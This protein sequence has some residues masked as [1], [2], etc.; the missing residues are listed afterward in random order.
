MYKQSFITILLTVL[1][2]MTGAK[3]FAHDIYAAYNGK[4]IYYVWTNNNTELAVS[5]RGSSSTSYNNEYTG[6]VEIP[7]SVEYKG[8]TYPVTYIS[9]LAF[10]GCSSLTSVTIPI[11]VTSIGSEAFS[12]C[13]G[14]TSVTIPNSVESI[15]SYAF[16]E[17]S[18]LRSVT[19]PGSVTDIGHYAFNNCSSLK[20]VIVNCS[21]TTIG[22]RPFYNCNK[23]EEVSF[24]C[25]T[26]SQLFG[27]IG[28]KKVTLSE[29][30]KA[31]GASAL[32]GFSITSV[33]IPNSVTRIGTMAFEECHGLTSI[34]IPNSVT[35][36]GYKAF[37]FCGGLTTIV[38]E[39]E[40]P[41]EIGSIASTSVTLIVPAGTKAAYQSTA[42]W[43][44]FTKT[45]EIGEGGYAGCKF[46]NN[47]IIYTIGEN[48]TASLTSTNKS[49]S[50]AVDIPSQV[51][52]NG[53]MYDMTS[54]ADFA[55]SGRSLTSVTIPNSVTSIGKSAFYGC[56]ALGSVTIPNSVTSVGSSAF[57]NTAWYVNQP[58]GLIYVG[59]VAYKYKGEM[60]ENT[61]I[62]INDGTLG[63]AD[64]VFCDHYNLRSIT[65]PNS[66]TS[67]GY[68]AFRK[69]NGL[70]SVNISDMAAWCNIKFSG[71]YSNPLYCAHHLYINGNEITN[72]V[73]PN[74]VTSIGSCAFYGCTG[75]T[76]ATIP[77][78]VTSIGYDA[79]R[80]C[81]GLRSVTIPNSVT[82]IDS[83]AFSGCRRL[84]S[85][86]IPNSVTSI[87]TGVFYGCY[88][89]GSVTIP[90]SVTSI[91]DFAFSGCECLSSVP[92]PN[93]VTSIGSFAF[94]R[95]T[96]FTSFTIPNSVT[97]IGGS[98]FSNCINLTSITIP[99]GVT[100]IGDGAFSG[101]SRLGSVTIPNSVT[102]ISTGV[103]SGCSG[104]RSVTIP[105][106]VT[107]IGESAFYGCDLTFITIPNSVTSIGGSA[108]SNSTNLTTIVSEIKNP[109]IINGSLTNNSVTLVVPVGTKEA[110]QSTSGWPSKI[111]EI[112]EGDFAGCIFEIDGI[113]Y[114]IG[115]NNTVST[116]AN[117]AIS[118]A[119]IIPS[120][121]ELKGKKY[122]VTSIGESAFY[123][124]SGL[125]SV[126]IPNSVTSIGIQAFYGCY[127]LKSAIIGS[128]VLSIGADAFSYTNLK[129]TIWLTNTPPSGYNNAKGTVNYVSND[130]FNIDNKVVYKHLSSNFVV[131]GIRYVP[132]NPSQYTCDAIDCTYN[133]SVENINIGE[134][135]TNK[136]I[137]LTVLK[138]NP[139]TCYQNNHIKDVKLSLGGD[140]GGDAFYGCAGLNTA[141]VSNKGAIGIFAFSYCSA[142]ETAELGQDVTSIGKCA[143]SGCS[144]LES[145][146][147]P[148]AVVSIGDNAFEDCTSIISANIGNGVVTINSAA[149]AG[150]SSLSAITIPQSVKTI[151]YSVFYNCTSLA[152]VTIAD[153]ETTLTLYP[154]GK[155]PTFSSCPLDYVYIGRD[156]SYSTSSDYGYSPFYNNTSLRAVKI[157]DKETEISEKEFY[158]C[159]NLQQVEIGDGVTTIGSRAFSG[160]SGLTSITIPNCVE[161][162]SSYAFED[163]ISLTSVVIPDAVN[164]LGSYVFKDCA[165]MTSAKIGNGIETIDEYT[166]SGCT[167]LNE[168]NIGSK[169]ETIN[170]YAFSGCSALPSITIPKAVTTIDDY[171][172]S[173]CASLAEVTIADSET[174]LTLGSNGSNPIFSDCPLNNVYIGRDISYKT[175]SNYGYSPFYRNTS[176]RVVK[177]A[178]SET[179]ISENEFYGCTNLRQVEIGDGMTTI[180]NRAFS[181]CSS[182][183]F[184]AFG[185]QMANIGQE[186]FSDCTALVA[187]TSKAQTPPVCG[188]QALDDI[189]RWECKLYVPKGYLSVYQAADQW[190]DFWH[191][192]EG[193]YIPPM[194]GD[195]NS[196]G[197]VDKDDLRDL[198][199]YIMGDKPNG[200]TE[201]SA[202]VNGDNK[203]NITDI[204]VL[205]TLLRL[206]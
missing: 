127:N 143:F 33:T 148:D 129:K 17:C 163:C 56:Y 187:I 199:A 73:I 145:I 184:F 11:S 103:F 167:S 173:N 123:G 23:I 25:E 169:V 194:E 180:G 39:I 80:D 150:C 132:V 154:V 131:D 164:T 53:K 55:F 69:C 30:I 43:S 177:I 78:S 50:G 196:D 198:V 88:A 183:K 201:E 101:C 96:C 117:N 8:N 185:S 99:N 191:M 65:I 190:M 176:L 113:Y 181:G 10:Y 192:Y 93:S 72:L 74:S 42:G 63:I 171:V 95:C 152:K 128:G 106:S 5:Y 75:L 104:L 89:L 54:I 7:N 57:S 109:F 28:I 179:E 162:I 142:L 84:E 21:P 36:I 68:D 178:D 126:T 165:A 49:I 136:N 122:D 168:I 6:N 4:T 105:K 100:S 58:D 116:T 47:G 111:I 2:S 161:S 38:S 153:S 146:D 203:V 188:S 170:Q 102:S 9:S 82:S 135:V 139:Y 182:L 134:T 151:D 140:I 118:D 141:T 19:I 66:V 149:F 144:K 59:K 197:K 52:L 160:C 83:Y 186:A 195:V 119:I 121:V 166:F 61:T 34:T 193:E 32:A 71:N 35:D 189:N 12:N 94:Y 172:F 18:G 130:Q 107:S 40:T 26:V 92:I 13:S 125:T 147:I 14:L 175:G 60:P 45:V 16:S 133:A 112:G 1:M 3:A 24:D 120:Q 64:S 91:A 157:T 204:V 46:E 98:A 81:S 29:N 206:Q 114:T 77:S 37:G 108:F 86:T 115:E 124:C 20:S 41:F 205:V 90:N 48:N 44:S 159:T 51:E 110:Y 138:V 156:I 85:V 158:G 155:S 27:G 87:S 31:I 137:T 67:I 174:I 79:F 97:S 22:D 15:G 200:V 202:D 62:S 76:S 70:T